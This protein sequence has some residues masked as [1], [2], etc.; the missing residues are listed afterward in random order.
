MLIRFTF[1]FSDY[2]SGRKVQVGR[3]RTDGTR[4]SSSLYSFYGMFGH[5]SSAC[6]KVSF[7]SSSPSSS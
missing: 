7:L 4:V 2:L 6:R 5:C 3:D 1:Q